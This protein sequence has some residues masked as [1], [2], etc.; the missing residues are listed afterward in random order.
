MN[1][2]IHRAAL[3]LALSLATA[4]C[5]WAQPTRKPPEQL[6]TVSFTNSCAPAVQAPFERAVA[7]LHSF[8]WQ[9]GEKAFREV[10]E[11]DPDCAIA[12][13]GIASILIGNVFATGPTPAAAQRA[14]EATIISAGVRSARRP[15]ASGPS[16]RR[17]PRTTTASPSAHTRRV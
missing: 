3:V 16:S 9:E 6:G 10:L 5:A 8:W 12:T 7:L 15:S 4:N 17:S 13:W 2:W 11:R 14:Q 1:M